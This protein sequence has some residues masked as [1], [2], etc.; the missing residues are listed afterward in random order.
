MVIPGTCSFAPRRSS[1]V[2]RR[3]ARRRRAGR[4]ARAA[5]VL[6]LEVA[7]ALALISVIHVEPSAPADTTP[8]ALSTLV[9][10]AD[11]AQYRAGDVRVRATIV[12]HPERVPDG[13][14]EP[15]CSPRGPAA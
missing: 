4:I 8:R 15:S 2:H 7:A 3:A 9:V 10:A 1:A 12:E 6:G 11:P 13:G 5:L 14:G